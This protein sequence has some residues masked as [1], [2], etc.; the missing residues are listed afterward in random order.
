MQIPSWP[1]IPTQAASRVISSIPLRASALP[2]TFSA[3]AR[4]LFVADMEC[5]TNMP[6]ETKPTPKEWKGRLH[7]S[8]R[9]RRR[10]MFR[11]IT[12]SERR[13]ERC[14]P[15]SHSASIRFPPR[16]YGRICNN[17]IST[18]SMNCRAI[19][20]SLCHTWA[21]KEPTWDCSAT[22]ISFIRCPPARILTS[23]ASR[24]AVDLTPAAIPSMTTAAL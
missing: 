8:S 13:L 22:S 18:F 9:R 4:L 12:I 20:S 19:P 1:A 16:R 17:G 14:L 6:M 24:S 5:S 2:T 23:Q 3:M 11:A 10:A 15:A 21:A 7:L